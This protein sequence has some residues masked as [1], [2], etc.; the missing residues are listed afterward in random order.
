MQI[1]KN[2]QTTICLAMVF[3][4][5]IAVTQAQD[6]L[7]SRIDRAAKKAINNELDPSLIESELIE[8][9]KQEFNKQQSTAPLQPRPVTNNNNQ[10]NNFVKPKTTNPSSS[11]QNSNSFKQSNP[12]TGTKG[13]A[14]QNNQ[15]P[16]NQQN[17]SRSFSNQNASTPAFKTNSV[18]NNNI[19]VSN[20]VS[21]NNN[22]YETKSTPT[23]QTQIIAPRTTN[24]NQ[25]A[26]FF[27][28]AQNI[29]TT[30]VSNFK[31]IATLPQHAKFVGS[32]PQP[33]NVSGQ[34]YEFSFHTLNPRSKQTVQI[35]ITPTE[36]LPLNISTQIQI[37]SQQQVAVTVQ[38]PV[39][40]VSVQGPDA[41][42]T[43]KNFTHEVTVT[44]VGD[45]VAESVRISTQ[46][47]SELEIGTKNQKTLVPKLL[48]GQSAKF[49]LSSFAVAPGNADVVFQVSATGADQK[50]AKTPIRI[51][52]PEL[53]V[54]VLGP[55]QNYL[56]REGIYTIQLQNTS[57]MPI[58][59]VN[60]KLN[61]PTGL[62]IDTISQ[63]ANIDKNT[64]QLSWTF[65]NIPGNQQQVIQFRA[66][67]TQVGTQ[68]CQVS[69]QTKETASRQMSLKT[70]ILGR[71]DLSI[72]VT[73]MGEPVGI[74]AKSE[75]FVEV[76]NYGSINAENVQVRVEL[77]SALMPVNQP[78][79][80]IDPSG[81][82]ITFDNISVE[83]GKRHT[84]KFKVVAV[85]QGEH[86]VRGTVTQQGSV[87]SISSE[88][89]IFVF[90]TENIKVSDALVPEIRR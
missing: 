48:P 74:G 12:S 57:E 46:R 42:Q 37:E 76:G 28:Q 13:F 15:R 70:Q 80:T 87:N 38:Q 35:D 45:G 69:V 21:F 58:T 17:V 63:Q 6:S 62:K 24:I 61:V 90:D 33:S 30:N 22:T 51:I 43:G 31:L 32:N 41:I 7:S 20:N 52:R 72:R 83:A 82:F 25:T 59:G 5:P 9:S 26:R 36:K 53:G 3:F 71:A 67:A 8:A 49:E 86:I 18:V 16:F 89:S 29:G 60:V 40:Q 75:F 81:N 78:G 47:P 23:I 56:G 34:Q 54:Q 88:N 27:V 39:L 79:Y 50:Q 11:F 10:F 4:L 68:F 1:R 84:L 66:K 2:I 19:N 73:D 77:P 14:N 55:S 44:N 65:N 85:T 64:G